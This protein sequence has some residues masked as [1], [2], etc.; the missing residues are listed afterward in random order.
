MLIKVLCHD[1]TRQLIAACTTGYSLTRQELSQ[2]HHLRLAESADDL[3]CVIPC[4]TFVAGLKPLPGALAVDPL[5]RTQSAACVPP[6][7][8][9][10]SNFFEAGP[11][12]IGRRHFTGARVDEKAWR[13]LGKPKTLHSCGIALFQ[14]NLE[15]DVR[16]RIAACRQEQ[17]GPPRTVQPHNACM[18]LSQP[19]QLPN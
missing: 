13:R 12:R 1:L 16:V 7:E 18:F 6:E 17:K 19:I 2:F 11:V 9:L 14:G 4:N 3:G 10:E 5:T 15:A 8:N